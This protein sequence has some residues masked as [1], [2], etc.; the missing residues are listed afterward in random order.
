MRNFVIATTLAIIAITLTADADG[1]QLRF[2]NFRERSTAWREDVTKAMK[3]AKES[4]RPMVL[5]FHATWCGP[6]RE[7]ER[8][9]LNTRDVQ[10]SLSRDFVAIRVD[11]DE[12]PELA[13]RYSIT[14]LPSDLFLSPTGKVLTRTEGVLAK[15][16]YLSKLRVIAAKYPKPRPVAEKKPTLPSPSLPNVGPSIPN[17]VQKET[18]PSEPKKELVTESKSKPILGL[19]GFSPVHLMNTRKWKRGDSD[20][21]H[22]YKGIT[23]RLADEKE[24][25]VFKESPEK[26]APRVLGC[27]PVIL[28]EDDRAVA[29]S[30]Q[31][32]AFFDD[33]LFLFASKENRNKFK[34]TPL[35]YTRTKHAVKPTEIEG[36]RFQ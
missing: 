36:Q 24:L 8:D 26:F 19:D 17:V 25:A 5:H 1:P 16:V 7:M 14:A 34:T 18:E 15:R 21:T 35:R 9:V 33:E 12:Y 22:T 30:T 10:Q 6:C 13:D 11:S 2:V 20:L 32:G 31:Y 23:Y 3:E 4:K 27:D 29:G 28:Y